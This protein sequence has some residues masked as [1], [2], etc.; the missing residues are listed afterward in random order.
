[1]CGIA[2]I[3][4]R[5]KS[6]DKNI[7]ESALN[8]ML[9]RGMDDINIYYNGYNV[10]FGYI[11]LAIRGLDNTYSQPIVHNNYIAFGNGEVYNRNG[12]PINA[13][14]CDLLSIIS[15]IPKKLTKIYDNYD[16]DFALSIYD[17]N[18][19]TFFLARDYF[20][21]KPLFYS[22]IDN[23]T[24]AFAS[25]IKG[26]LMLIERPEYDEK[27]IMDYLLFGYSLNEKT[28][29]KNVFKLEPRTI[30]K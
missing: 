16:A 13:N 3:I 5:N 11:R 4:S 8:K 2:G 25:E 27:T 7:V 9:H 19:N 18:K 22:W 12:K 6:V 24:L 21:V 17:K 29:Y 30:F 10:A 1:M 15:D 28:F 23:D 14:Q 26:L 20:G